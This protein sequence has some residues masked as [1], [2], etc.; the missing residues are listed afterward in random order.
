MRN[1]HKIAVAALSVL[2][3]I[4][5][6]AYSQT[7]QGT[8]S[9]EFIHEYVI[10]AGCAVLF[11]CWL[12][13]IFMVQARLKELD[14]ADV[15]STIGYSRSVPDWLSPHRWAFFL[16]VIFLPVGLSLCSRVL[17]LEKTVFPPE[18]AYHF[19]ASIFII[20]I[21][22]E[23]AAI[24]NLSNDE[25][26]PLL[27]AALTIDLLAFV[28]Y[29]MMG[30]PASPEVENKGFMALF[31]LASGA[32]SLA[33]S[34]LTLYHARTYERYLRNEIPGIPPTAPGELKPAEPEGQPADDS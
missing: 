14:R 18:L 33:S 8:A 7:D 24:F 22:L 28:G 23:V 26:R 11:L 29:S 9:D 2:G 30:Q 21:T 15:Q 17:P 31:F 4:P 1:V 5:L 12:W 20:M 25:W 13:Q 34:F 3:L 19:A 32:T 10:F 16:V 6:Q 27:T